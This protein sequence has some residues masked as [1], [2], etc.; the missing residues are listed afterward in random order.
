MKLHSVINLITNSSTEIFVIDPI[1]HS[2][3]DVKK[4]VND[5]LTFQTEE[6][7]GKLNYLGF[8]PIVFPHKIGI[9]PFDSDYGYV[10]ESDE[11]GLVFKEDDILVVS[12]L[13]G[14]SSLVAKALKPISKWHGQHEDDFD[15]NLEGEYLPL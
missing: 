8:E 1:E 7:K 10:Y 15:Q 12:V 3:D 11:E 4:L 5:L 6:N 2:Y 13:G 9:A 14:M